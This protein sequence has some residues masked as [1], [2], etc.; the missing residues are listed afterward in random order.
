MKTSY[1]YRPAGSLSRQKGEREMSVMPELKPTTNFLG[2]LVCHKCKAKFMTADELRRLA[3]AIDNEKLE[4][5]NL[6][7][8]DI[9][10][11]KLI[12][13][14]DDGNRRALVLSHELEESK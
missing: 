1:D 5:K 10:Y 14:E 4:V 12:Y 3:D 8:H 6:E 11:S 2:R 7:H 9:S 13:L